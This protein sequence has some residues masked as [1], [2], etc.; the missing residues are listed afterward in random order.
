MAGE[1]KLPVITGTDSNGRSFLGLS[2]SAKRAFNSLGTILER[3][4]S[5]KHH[6]RSEKLEKLDSWYEQRQYASLVGWEEGSCSAPPV[7]VRKRS[8]RIVVGIERAI[9]ER[10]TSKLIGN[11]TFPTLSVEEDPDTTAFL[12]AVVRFA[13]IR[14][15]LLEPIR[16]MLAVGSSFV[17]FYFVEGIVKL[18]RYDSK[19]C[20][21]TFSQSGELSSLRVKY[22]Y[23]TENEKDARGNPVC[24]WYQLDLGEMVDILYDN[25][26]YDPKNPSQE[27]EFKEQSRVEHGLGYVQGEWLRTCEKKHSPDGDSLI[28]DILDFSNEMNYS[29][30][31][32]SVAIGYNQDPQLLVSGMDAD[33]L[34]ELIRS[35]SKAWNLG[36]DGKGQFLESNLNGVKVAGEFRD[37]VYHLVQDVARVVLLDPEKIVGSAQSA[38]AMEVLHGPMVEL[39]NELR[40]VVEDILV[41]LTLKI[42][43]TILQLHARGEPVGMNLPEGWAPKSLNVTLLWPP[44]FPMTMQD[45]QTKVAVGSAAASGN[46]VSRE[47]ITR[48]L[49]KDFGIEDVEMEIQKIAAQPI[50]NP[51]G[52]F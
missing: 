50:I 7:P 46:L 21:P 1:R 28:E 16:R 39:V 45:L 34:E 24:R 47:T 8:P 48:W 15:H 2:R 3:S 41:R 33:Q 5:T 18:E 31:Q 23:E 44:V 26:I 36:R 35:S 12:Q 14:L 9:C 38:K 40:P 17:R 30:S 13:K 20:Y 25:P 11:D 10:T 49:A 52:G 32:S 43:V 29:L 6:F 37:K 42:A 51:F 4:D 19:F 27:P 22:V